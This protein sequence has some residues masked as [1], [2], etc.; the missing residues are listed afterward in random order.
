MS[1]QL[2]WLDTVDA[3]SRHGAAH[4]GPTPARR[5]IDKF[6]RGGLIRRLHR[7]TKPPPLRTTFRVIRKTLLSI[8]REDEEFE[9]DET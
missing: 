8:T 4:S 3:A 9:E 5:L 6:Y 2:S 1:D 7:S